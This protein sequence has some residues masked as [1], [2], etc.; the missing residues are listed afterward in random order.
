MARRKK[1]ILVRGYYDE[2]YNIVR[3]EPIDLK[4]QE[5]YKAFQ[6]ATK[7]LGGEPERGK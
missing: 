4:E 3:V 6:Q 2:N 1:Q 5:Y 7:A